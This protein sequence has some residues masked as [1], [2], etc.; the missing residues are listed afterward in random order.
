MVTFHSVFG[1]RLVK[2]AIQFTEKVKQAQDI[3]YFLLQLNMFH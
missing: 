3:A 2:H 1:M